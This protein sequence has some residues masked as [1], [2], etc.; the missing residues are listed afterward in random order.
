MGGCERPERVA[1]EMGRDSQADFTLNM[2]PGAVLIPGPQD[3]DL[4]QIQELVA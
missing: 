3:D 4:S 2:E 1:G